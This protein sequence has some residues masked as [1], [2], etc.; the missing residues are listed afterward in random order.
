MEDEKKTDMRIDEWE[1]KQTLVQ[2]M[3]ELSVSTEN[4]EKNQ[5]ERNGKREGNQME[6]NGMH[7][8]LR[9][10]VL[11]FRFGDRFAFDRVS[12]VERMHRS[13]P[14]RNPTCVVRSADGI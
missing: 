6:S 2:F 10:I 9:L 7:F 12:R 1:V 8:Y 5:T 14:Q 4:Q 13:R 3:S 11:F